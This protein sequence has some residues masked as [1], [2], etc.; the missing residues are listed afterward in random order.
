[1]NEPILYLGIIL[2]VMAAAALWCL[3]FVNSEDADAAL[4]DPD[5]CECRGCGAYYHAK[6]GVTQFQRPLTMPRQ[7]WLKGQC[8]WCARKLSENTFPGAGGAVNQDRLISP[9]TP[10]PPVSGAGEKL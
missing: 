5:W 1:M 9:A 6:T 4:S 3:L 7:F 10:R 8:P 2:G